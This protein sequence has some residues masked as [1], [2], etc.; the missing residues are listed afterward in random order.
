MNEEKKDKNKQKVLKTP[1]LLTKEDEE[2][3]KNDTYEHQF[4]SNE[5]DHD[6]D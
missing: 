1:H 2:M 5:D 6:R 3:F 4:E